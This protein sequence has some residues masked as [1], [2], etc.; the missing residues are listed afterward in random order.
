MTTS[1]STTAIAATW[2]T[3]GLGMGDLALP[4]KPDTEQIYVLGS[5]FGG[6]RGSSVL[7][8]NGPPQS[9]EQGR[10]H[11]TEKPIGLMLSLLAKCPPGI[12]VDPFMGSGTTLRAAKDL[13]RQAIGI[14]VDESYCRTA[15]ARLGQE[16]LA[17]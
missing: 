4:W 8:Y 1:S 11:P 3:C 10:C 9:K 14:E 5:G 17:L 12:I 13:G 6:F 2:P 16:V 7:T 15:V